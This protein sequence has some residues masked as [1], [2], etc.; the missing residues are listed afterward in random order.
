MVLW[1]FILMVV[2]FA[3][4]FV[5]FVAGGLVLV[6]SWVLIG[7]WVLFTLF[8]LYFFRDPSPN[9]PQ[10]S[11]LVVAPGHGKVDLID[12]TDEPRF[13]GGS[14]QRVSIFLSVFDVHVQNAPVAG[15]V[16]FYQYTEGKFLN[17]MKA[18]SAL[19]NENAL[20]GIESADPQGARIGVRLI[21]GLIARRIVP[22][23]TVGESL[24]RGERISLIQFG[25][26]V[27]LYLPPE[28]KVRVMLGQKVVGGQ[29]VIASFD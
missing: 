8:T 29:T 6:F 14:C 3:A 10:G 20:I 24:E 5:G 21:A 2:I 25:S 27:D 23:V 17:A 12:T 19:H 18:D 1:T 22:W 28:A 26:R 11:K 7:L 16:K 4:A 13:M 9:V 15:V